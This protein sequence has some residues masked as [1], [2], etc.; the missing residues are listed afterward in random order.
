MWDGTAGGAWMWVICQIVATNLQQQIASQSSTSNKT[1]LPA[2][3]VCCIWRCRSSVLDNFWMMKR[4]KAISFYEC[5]R[6]GMKAAALISQHRLL[7]SPV[8]QAVLVSHLSRLPLFW[9]SATLVYRA[10][11]AKSNRPFSLNLNEKRLLRVWSSCQSLHAFAM[12][13]L[14]ETLE[15]E[16]TLPN[17]C[18]PPGYH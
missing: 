14:H 12:D 8:T 2:Y 17:Y 13:W 9:S 15:G 11:E 7:I 10:A 4:L 3:G 6:S 1:I 16:G 18:Q 5:T